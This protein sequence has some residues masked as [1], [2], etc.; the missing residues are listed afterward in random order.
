MTD[1]ERFDLPL[2]VRYSETDQMGQAYYANYL[3]W[4]EAA[5]GHLMREL[6]LPYGRLEEE[7]V[8]LP[9]T[10][11]AARLARPA[12][13]DDDLRVRLRVT[14]LR[15]RGV[16]FAYRVLRDGE[17]LAEG[18]TEHVSVDR[19]GRPVRLPARALRLLEEFRALAPHPSF[20]GGEAYD[21]T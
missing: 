14:G 10:R 4:F 5:R 9:V 17:L 19:G 2:R 21:P 18:S 15:S 3:V 1:L 16:T 6:G 7:G 11:F 20:P 13:Y 8:L 12:R